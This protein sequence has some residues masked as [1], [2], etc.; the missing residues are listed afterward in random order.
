V[1]YHQE[2]LKQNQNPHYVTQQNQRQGNLHTLDT[3]F[4]QF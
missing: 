1:I 3:H 2:Y 4:G